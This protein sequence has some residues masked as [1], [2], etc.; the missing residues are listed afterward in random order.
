MSVS[1]PF[2]TPSEQVGS[3]HSPDS[4]TPLSQSSASVHSGDEV[5]AGPV[6]GATLPPLSV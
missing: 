2:E 5:S 3:M 1:S 4:Q 6:S